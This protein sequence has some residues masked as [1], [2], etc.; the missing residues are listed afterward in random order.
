MQSEPYNYK[1]LVENPEAIANKRKQLEDE[2]EEYKNYH[3]ELN[4]I[5]LELLNGGDLKIHVN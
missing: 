2:L 4:K 1:A 5:I 3:K